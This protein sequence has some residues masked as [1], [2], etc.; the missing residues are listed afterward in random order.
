MNRKELDVRFPGS[1]SAQVPERTFESY[2]CQ[3][4][5]CFLQRMPPPFWLDLVLVPTFRV[6]VGPGRERGEISVLT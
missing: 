1:F 4:R 3:K 6:Y 5:L 2:L